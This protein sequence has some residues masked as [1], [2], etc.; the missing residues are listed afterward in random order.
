MRDGLNLTSSAFASWRVMSL[1]I[2]LGTRLG[3]GRSTKMNSINLFEKTST[4][5]GSS[6]IKSF[7]KYCHLYGESF[8][9]F[10][11]NTVFCYPPSLWNVLSGPL[12]RHGL[13]HPNFKVFW[14]F[15]ASKILCFL[16]LMKIFCIACVPILYWCHQAHINN[17]CLPNQKGSASAIPKR[18]CHG[19]GGGYN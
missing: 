4:P 17:K 1:E 15:S 14:C 10:W 7:F 8:Y 16:C 11:L 12:Y 3:G 13:F 5:F 18:I 9:L 19:L 6:E 2:Q